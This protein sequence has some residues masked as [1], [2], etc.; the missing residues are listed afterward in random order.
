MAT[1][2]LV[3]SPARDSA[4]VSLVEVAGIVVVDRSPE[5]IAQ[6]THAGCRTAGIMDDRQ[7]L[8]RCRREAG[9][10]DRTRSSPDARLPRGSTGRFVE[11]EDRG[12]I[13]RA[14]DVLYGPL[15][16]CSGLVHRAEEM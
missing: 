7:L 1:R 16:S 5:S 9:L 10:Q 2:I 13:F 14:C 11:H 3:R 8:T 6:I 4:T 15:F 12:G